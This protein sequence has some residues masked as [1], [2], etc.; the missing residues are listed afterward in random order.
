MR[1]FHKNK[2]QPSLPEV[3][4]ASGED[5]SEQPPPQQ[6]ANT[7]PPVR[8][9]L[10]IPGD[11]SYQPPYPYA[12]DQSVHPQTQNYEENYTHPAHAVS[13]FSHELLDSAPTSSHHRG[14]PTL[15]L[16]PTSPSLGL[17]SSSDLSSTEPP[18]TPHSSEASPLAESQ[19]RKFRKGLFGL[20]SKHKDKDSSF[21]GSKVLGRTISV[22][23][24]KEEQP[25][26]S[27]MPLSKKTS[28]PPYPPAV[29]RS[30]SNIEGQPFDPPR[31][32]R[33]ST[34]PLSQDLYPPRNSSVHQYQEGPHL[35]EAPHPQLQIDHAH[36]QHPSV[37]YQ[38]SGPQ[39]FADQVSGPRSQSPQLDPYLTPRPP[40]QQS[41]GP[42]SPLN[43]HYQG[44][45]SNQHKSHFRQSLQPPTGSTQSGMERQ[46]GL[47]QPSEPMGQNPQP[48]PTQPPSVTP[49]SSF[50]GNVPQPG[51]GEVDRDTPLHPPT[52]GRDEAPE[53]DVRALT[54]KYEELRMCHLS[55]SF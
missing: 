32:Q 8:Y 42:P 25:T 3:F 24:S 7:H 44:F 4:E 41:F 53:I 22:R 54:Q 30:S 39:A 16:V 50:K 27:R 1:L 35:S 17:G 49:G 46:T 52:K 33:V 6:G 2:S 31:I 18:Y 47:R 5:N 19:P 40:S 34:E 45:E 43:P 13:R 36:L 38:L 26:Q 20:S 51:S 48:Q 55:F 15:N 9:S 23:Q 11:H 10:V 29:N 21:R 28:Q 12:N 37:N 14:R